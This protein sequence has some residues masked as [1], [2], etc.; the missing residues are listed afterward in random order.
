[1]ERV[2]GIEPALSAREAGLSRPTDRRL[3]VQVLSSGAGE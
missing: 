3:A 2:A 1:L